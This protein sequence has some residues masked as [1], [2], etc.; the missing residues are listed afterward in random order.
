MEDFGSTVAEGTTEAWNTVADGTTEAWETVSTGT[1]EFEEN[2]RDG[3][4]DSKVWNAG[5]SVGNWWNNR[6]RVLSVD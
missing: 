6:H 4:Q 2:V 1:M 5:A 3:M